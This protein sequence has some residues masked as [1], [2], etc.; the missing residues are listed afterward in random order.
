MHSLGRKNVSANDHNVAFDCLKY[1]GQSVQRNGNTMRQVTDTAT[2]VVPV[3][4][5]LY[6][7]LMYENY[8]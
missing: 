7:S 8:N 1:W 3:S 2:Y 4:Y 5:N 6:S